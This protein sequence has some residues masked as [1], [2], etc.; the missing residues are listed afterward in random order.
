MAYIKVRKGADGSP[1]YTAVIRIR[2]GKRSPWGTYGRQNDPPAG[3]AL[4]WN[5]EWPESSTLRARVPDSSFE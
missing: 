4:H 5:W 2:S 3:P 1:R